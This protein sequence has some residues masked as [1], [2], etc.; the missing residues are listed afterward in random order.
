M[1]SKVY[2]HTKDCMDQGGFRVTRFQLV[3]V[4]AEGFLKFAYHERKGIGNVQWHDLGSSVRLSGVYVG[5]DW[6]GVVR[7]QL[8]RADAELALAVARHVAKLLRQHGFGIL[9]AIVPEY[10]EAGT[11]IGEHDISTE[12]YDAY[13]DPM[14]GLHSTELKVRRIVCEDFRQTVRMQLRKQAEALWKAVIEKPD[15]PWRSRIVLLVE[16]RSVEDQTWAAVRADILGYGCTEWKG[17]FGW[18]GA[19]VSAGQ[20]LRVPARP[21]PVAAPLPVGVKRPFNS[22]QFSWIQV[23]GED[24]ASVSLLLDEIRTRGAKRA[25]PTLARRM[26]YWD[27]LFQWPE[28]SHDKDPRASSRTGGGHAGHV[29]TEDALYDIYSLF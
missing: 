8:V 12:R 24:M 21:P 16:F 11:K 2:D 26:E 10:D 14:P 28:G 15:S 1:A 9:D 3:G 29:A 19:S 20:P 17:L 18:Q 4:A 25:K 6:K 7:V 13:Q 23:N 22:L 5:G 27:R